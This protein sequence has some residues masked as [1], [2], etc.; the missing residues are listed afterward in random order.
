VQAVRTGATQVRVVAG[1]YAQ[2][3][4]TGNLARFQSD[5]FGAVGGIAYDPAG[6]IYVVEGNRIDVVTLV[7][8]DDESTWTVA[9]FAGDLAAGA[10]DGSAAS[11]RFSS[12]AGLY[13]DGNQ[14]YVADAGNNVIR[15]IDLSSG[16]VRTI[17]GTMAKRGFF[18]DGDLATS[19]LLFEPQAIT[20]CGKNLFVA[21]TGN[22]RVRRVTLDDGKIS[23]VLGDGT[24][25]SSGEGDP[26]TQFPVNN[27]LAVACDT[28]GNLYVT[29]TSAVRVVTIDA[30]GAAGGSGKALTIYSSSPQHPFET[31]CL[32]GLAVVDDATV[33]V[34]DACNGLMV[35]LHR[36]MQSHL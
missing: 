23:T 11:A 7:D 8:P 24:S 29:S 16:I 27:P 6:F 26:S 19:A 30:S 25:S 35:L 3:I 28:I 22:N 5:S 10:V 32:S 36:T 17:V 9:S 13:L 21:D 4:A 14:L 2:T 33:E 1:R 15:A 20:R 31:P 18:G 34:A 12:P